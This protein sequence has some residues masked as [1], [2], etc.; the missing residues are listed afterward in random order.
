MNNLTRFGKM[1]FVLS[2]I[3]IALGFVC[4]MNLLKVEQ[5]QTFAIIFIG[6]GISLGFTSLIYQKNGRDS[7]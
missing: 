7:A 5:S 3:F 2:V 6:L 1:N 4:M